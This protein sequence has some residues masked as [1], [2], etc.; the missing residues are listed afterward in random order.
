[1]GSN[2]IRGR[3]ERLE[4]AWGPG[5]PA[6]GIGPGS[7]IEYV[8]DWDTEEPRESGALPP[9]SQCGREREV[10]VNWDDAK[11]EPDPGERGLLET[12]FARASQ[13]KGAG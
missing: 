3:L 13:P 2:G 6:C 4:G 7:P 12:S 1:M 8:V 9:C 10:V 5:C 11:P